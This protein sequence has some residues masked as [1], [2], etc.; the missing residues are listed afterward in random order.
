MPRTRTS[1]RR[2][3]RIPRNKI[4]GRGFY[5]GFGRDV[6]TFLGTAA[7]RLTGI[8]GLGAVGGRLG[9]YGSKITGFGAYDTS[10]AAGR[11]V[12]PNNPRIAN[13]VKLE[14]GVIIN[15]REYIGD[16][17]SSTA[18]TKKYELPLNPAMPSS[19]PWL[20][21]TAANFQEYIPMG[22][23]YEYVSS[24]GSAVSSTNNAL[25]SVMMSCQY[26]S[27]DQAY[28]SKAEML[29]ENFAQ[30]FAPSC[31]GAL[32]I[33]CDR[34]QS[35]L[36]KH[37]TRHGAVEAGADI[38]M[39]DLGKVTVATQGMQADDIVVGSLYVNYQFA[40]LKPQLAEGIGELA[41]T[42]NLGLNA[43]SITSAN[44]II[45]TGVN[46]KYDN[47][48]VSFAVVGGKDRIII[49][50]NTVGKFILYAFWGGAA[51]A[52]CA[53]P[54]VLYDNLKVISVLG[55]G[56]YG[57]DVGMQHCDSHTNTTTWLVRTIEVIESSLG[58]YIEFGNDGVLPGSLARANLTITQLNRDVVSLN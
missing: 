55:G 20:S 52:V 33:E 56:L 1:R 11:L 26:N 18:F 24:S 17:T 27:M 6:G 3:P 13:E 16:V 30:S 35:V 53:A 5:K 31:N 45:G 14:G 50:P 58:G 48:G 49:P 44:P 2:R 39:Y 7:G 54:T 10:N 40:L 57:D 21:G 47:I 46:V 28:G 42:C 25:G 34:E 32:P 15:H 29:N 22:I 51:S 12:L 41:A 8:P 37:Y 38:R 43:S 9:A 36:H 23:I 19:F 4:T